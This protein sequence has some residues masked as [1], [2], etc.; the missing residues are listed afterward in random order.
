MLAPGA[1]TKTHS[2]RH[3]LEHIN[4]SVALREYVESIRLILTGE[5][6]SYHGQAVNFDDVKLGF[7]PYRSY[8]PMYLPATSR[9]GLRLAGKIADGVLLNAICSPSTARTR[10]RSCASRPRRR[11]ATGR[12]S[13]S[14]S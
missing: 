5:R 12:S 14:R 11:D 13:R 3:G 9:A 7:T 8:I 6:V 4:A 2:L 10:S 1:C